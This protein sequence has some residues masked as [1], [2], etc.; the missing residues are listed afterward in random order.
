MRGLLVAVELSVA[1]LAIEAIGAY[2]SRSLSLTVD[3]VHNIPDI[4]AFLFSWTAIRV[5]SHGARGDLTFGAHRWE[6]FAGLLNAFLVLGT[7]LLFAYQ[8]VV[9]IIRG[10]TFAGAVDPIWILAVAIPTLCLRMSNL[11]VLGRIPGR[12]RDLN[13]RSVLVHLASDLAITAALLIAGA[14][15]LLRAGLGWADPA[16]ALA[17][18]AILVVESLPLFRDGWDILTEKSPRGLSLEAITKSAVAIPG[19]RGLHDVHVWSV[20]S[21]LV[22]LMAHVDVDDMTVSNSM[23]VIAQLRKRMESEYGIVHS[24]FEIEAPTAG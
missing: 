14:V 8:A 18:G 20:C 4:L 17:I 9:Q 15:I 7:G 1:I 11:A 19:I 16:A 2:F 5:S 6:T 12:V 3:T 22:C 10:G 24:T 21:S 13:L 23:K